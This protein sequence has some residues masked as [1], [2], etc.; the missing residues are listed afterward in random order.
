MNTGTYQ[1]SLS[2]GQILNLVRQ[3]PGR[4]KAKLNK[5]LAKEAID[6]RLSRLLNSFQTDE[7]SEEE[8]NTEVEKVRAEI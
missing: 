7:I 5:E 6:K 1:I 8:I 3:L 2:Y 4:E